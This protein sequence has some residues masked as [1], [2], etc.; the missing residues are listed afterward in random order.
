VAEAGSALTEQARPWRRAFLWLLFLAPFFYLTYGG[1]NWLAAHR[2][3]VPSMVFDWEHWIPFVAWTI[4]PYWSI[5]AFY[6]LSFFVCSSKAELDTHGLRLL[7]AQV[8]AV[9]CFI[10][11]PLRFT[12][13]QP[14]TTG[15]PGFLFDALTSFD[16]PFNQAPSLHIALC[17]ILWA[18][19]VRHVPRFGLP[20]LNAWFLLVAVS[21]LTTYQHHFIDLPTGLL[22]GLF[23]LWL[24]PTEQTSPL[25]HFGFTA[26]PRRR[27]LALRYAL[28]AIALGALAF[29]I[30]GL[31]LL[32]FW[33]AVA[34][35]MVAANYA[36]FGAEGFQK[37]A[38][39]KMSVASRLLLAPYH[40]GAWINSRAW[41]R[42]HKASVAVADGVALGRIPSRHEGAS[43]ITIDLCAE[44]PGRGQRCYAFPM[45]DLVAPDPERML[46]AS[47]AIEAARSEGPVL[48]YCAL[49]VSR[50]ASAVATWLAVT[51]RAASVEEAI[52]KVR[53]VRPRIVLGEDAKRAIAEAVERAR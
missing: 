25:S 16:Q 26:D 47:R 21:V 50:S 35:V 6:G 8:I 39:G 14:E 12:F 10:L 5:N 37:S 32:L 2:D 49:G 33:P 9:T 19:Y 46:A 42:S 44:L 22:L 36:L 17:V 20:L 31:G 52:E 41:T 28:G 34:L 11:F 15:F 4:I 23:C 18:L 53:T 43:H 51:G 48:V 40:A 29:V 30:G 38:D 45:L 7:T 1:A 3:G 27:R 13:A 24:W